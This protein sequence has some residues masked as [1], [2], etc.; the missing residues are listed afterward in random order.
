MV[1][2]ERL[3]TLTTGLSR[4]LARVSHGQLVSWTGGN[5]LNAAL[6]GRY[7]AIGSGLLAATHP[8]ACPTPAYAGPSFQP[9]RQSRRTWF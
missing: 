8:L 2:F 5:R 3:T 1:H 6:F 7:V 9:R 4:P